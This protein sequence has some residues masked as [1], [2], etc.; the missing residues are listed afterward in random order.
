MPV[1]RILALGI[2]LMFAAADAAYAQA[3]LPEAPCCTIVNGKYIDKKTGKEVMP[4]KAMAPHV[5]AS[6]TAGSKPPAVPSGGGGGS[7]YK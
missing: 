7:G 6:S 2:M 4:A 5:A 3:Q 1:T